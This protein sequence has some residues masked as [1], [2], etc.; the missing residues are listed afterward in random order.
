M[1]LLTAALLVFCVIL[2]SQLGALRRRLDRLEG[3]L[4]PLPASG[5]G[6]EPPESRPPGASIYAAQGAEG[7]GR[8]QKPAAPAQFSVGPLP[9]GQPPLF[10]NPP[11]V[12]PGRSFARPNLA[13]AG[14]QGAG[15]TP[16]LSVFAPVASSP[17][18]PAAPPR[19]PPSSRTIFALLGA[20]VTLGGA[21]WF[22][23][24]LARSGVLTREIQLDR[25]A[26]V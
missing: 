10:Q 9:V 16:P 20:A 18:A 6:F 3:Q 19:Q 5:P 12:W 13:A 25:R 21:A 15:Q 4:P 24:A 22:T 17:P 2:W 14:D 26:H 1:E 23:A 7:D 8:S 11:S